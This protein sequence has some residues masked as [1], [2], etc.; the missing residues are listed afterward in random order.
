MGLDPVLTAFY[1]PI[2][3]QKILLMFISFLIIVLLRCEKNA[4]ALL[5]ENVSYDLHHASVVFEQCL[6]HRSACPKEKKVMTL[7]LWRTLEQ[8]LLLSASVFL[9]TPKEEDSMVI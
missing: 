5:K 8:G 9:F 7:K 6:S 3:A 2:W 1:L 4:I